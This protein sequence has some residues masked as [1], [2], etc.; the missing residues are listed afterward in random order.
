MP[1]TLSD[2]VSTY[3]AYIAPASESPISYNFWSAATAISAVLKRN[4]W[5]GRGSYKLYP[6]LFTI[7][8][9]R[10]GIGKGSAINPVINLINE[11]KLVNTLSDRVTIEYVLERMSKGWPSQIRGPQ[12]GWILGQDHTTL[13]IS[14]EVSVFIG[15]SQNT[16]PILADLWDAREGEFVYGTRHKGE[17]RIKD[18][19]VCLLGG[20]TQEWLISSVPANAVGG[21]FTRRV[22][23]VVANDREKLLPWPILSNQHQVRDNLV[24]D[25]KSVGRLYGEYKFAKDVVPLFEKVYKDSSPQSTTT[26][27]LLRIR[28]VCGHK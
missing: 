8:V 19:C 26:R 3:V 14:P 7:L 4:V 9:G 2:W 15:A 12:G 18:P 25:I 11:A 13:I 17:F 27:R 10:P 21:G 1:R 22:N 5:V 6:N 20:S 23:F 28:R 16:L 24:T